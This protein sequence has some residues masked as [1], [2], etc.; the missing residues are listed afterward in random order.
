MGNMVESS[1]FPHQLYVSILR[2]PDCIRIWEVAMC[3]QLP[4]VDTPFDQ[5][6]H[7][8]IGYRGNPAHLIQQVLGIRSKQCCPKTDPEW[9]G[10]GVV[11]ISSSSH[12][13]K[14]VKMG[15]KPYIVFI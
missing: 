2:Y 10:K 3:E 12:S 9:K 11:G 6:S 8:L 5:E 4:I 1:C 14:P 13:T 15:K 7:L